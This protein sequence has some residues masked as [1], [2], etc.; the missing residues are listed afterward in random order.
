MNCGLALS[1]SGNHE[2]AASGNMHLPPPQSVR[3]RAVDADGNALAGAKVKHRVGRLSSWRLDGLRSVGEDCMR[4][5]G[6]TD[7]DGLCVV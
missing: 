1:A 2:D 6:V 3:V 5:L 7:D 4:S